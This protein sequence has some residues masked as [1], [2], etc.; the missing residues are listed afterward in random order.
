S[1]GNY[2]GLFNAEWGAGFANVS[3]VPDYVD[4]IPNSEGLLP[5]DRTHLFK[6]SGA[7]RSGIGLNVGASFIWQSG[8]PITELGR[9]G[10]LH[11]IFLSPRGT[12][13]RTPAFVDLNLRFKYDLG[14]FIVGGF[15]SMLVMDIFNVL[16]QRKAAT[17]NQTHY[18]G[19]DANSNP[20]L[21]NPDYLRPLRFYPERNVRLGMQIEF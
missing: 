10:P 5:N 15:H 16:N 19:V 6:F 2:T 21:P 7:Y 9:N 20:I 8:T 3:P 17:V 1:H 4:Q 11:P 12:A 18:F 14:K 13:G